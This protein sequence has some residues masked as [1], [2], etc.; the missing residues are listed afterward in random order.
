MLVTH[1]VDDFDKWKAVFDEVKPMRDEAGELSVALFRDASEPDT[2][3]ALFEWDSLDN[4]REYAGSDR[5][6]A[7]MQK[8]GVSVPPTISFLNAG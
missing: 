2:I 1:S 7:A 4:A 3:T 8:A 6:K 5:L